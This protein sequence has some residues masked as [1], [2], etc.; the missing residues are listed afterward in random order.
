MKFSGVGE[1]KVTLKLDSASTELKRDMETR[2]VLLK[3]VGEVPQEE[4]TGEIIFND[5]DANRGTIEDSIEQL[6]ASISIDNMATFMQSFDPQV[7]NESLLAFENEDNQEL[8]S[9]FMK[10]IKKSGIQKVEI[11]DLSSPFGDSLERKVHVFYEDQAN[12][13]FTIT[14]RQSVSEF[15]DEDHDK[16]RYL[17]TSSPLNI[18]NSLEK[19][20]K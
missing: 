3:A 1:E 2:N 15:H 20:I 16:G 14:F 10:D 5:K 9:G 8:I 6:F 7:L 18:I 12:S 19:N 13:H 17:I 11:Q 4:H